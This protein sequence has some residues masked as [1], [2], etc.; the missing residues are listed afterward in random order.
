MRIAVLVSGSGTLLEAILAE[1]IAVSLVLAD[2]SCRALDVAAGAGVAA[3]MV[4][5][6]DF[7]SAFDRGGYT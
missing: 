1:G 6:T 2:R 3:E 4:E 7:S 5:R